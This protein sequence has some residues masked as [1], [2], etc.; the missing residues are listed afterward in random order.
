MYQLTITNND[1]NFKREFKNKQKANMWIYN[2]LR[3]LQRRY[4]ISKLSNMDKNERLY[5]LVFGNWD[6][7]QILSYNNV[8]VEVTGIKIK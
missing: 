7:A 5:C 4:N 3:F 1:K 2:M 8:L 6:K